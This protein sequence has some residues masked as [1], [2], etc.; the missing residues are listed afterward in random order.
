M[1]LY[2]RILFHKPYKKILLYYKQV[3]RTVLLNSRKKIASLLISIH[4]NSAYNYPLRKSR[5][6]KRIYFEYE[7]NAYNFYKSEQKELKLIIL[8][9]L[10][11]F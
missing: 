6:L 5:K 4:Y 11:F 1:T 10:K 7:D 9:C 3:L 8:T 2:K